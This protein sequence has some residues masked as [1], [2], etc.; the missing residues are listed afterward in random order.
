[1]NSMFSAA[2]KIN[3]SPED[4]P[5]ACTHKDRRLLLSFP[6][7]RINDERTELINR[8]S[9]LAAPVCKHDG[10]V[11]VPRHID[12]GIQYDLLAI[13]AVHCGDSIDSAVSDPAFYRHIKQSMF[14]LLPDILFHRR[15]IRFQDRKVILHLRRSTVERISHLRRD[16][17]Q[18]A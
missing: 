16:L 14:P 17:I 4:L 8:E 9:F 2:L 7:H 13:L 3:P 10:R 12:D 11:P 1:M 5:P 18:I 15:Q 6:F